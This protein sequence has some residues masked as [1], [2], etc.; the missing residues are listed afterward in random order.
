M[1]SVKRFYCNAYGRSIEIS[2]PF[3]P[4]DL[5]GHVTPPLAWLDVSPC[6]V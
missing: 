4:F 3:Y 2:P 5:T 6:H 1:D